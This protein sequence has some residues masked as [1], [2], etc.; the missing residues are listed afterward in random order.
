M[1]DDIDAA[2]PLESLSEYVIMI[3]PF[4]FEIKL[5]QNPSKTAEKITKNLGCRN[6]QTA[7]LTSMCTFAFKCIDVTK[8]NV[9]NDDNIAEYLYPK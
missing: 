2:K 3:L 6:F 5:E 7:K 1:L 8:M 9:T 4:T